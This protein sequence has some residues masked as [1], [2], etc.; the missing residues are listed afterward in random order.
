MTTSWS[1]GRPTGLQISRTK[2]QVYQHDPLH[3][4]VL[5][6]DLGHEHGNSV[7]APEAHDVTDEETQVLDRQGRAEI[8]SIVNELRQRMSKLHTSGLCQ[9]E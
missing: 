5:V 8:S 7:Q 9:V 4:D 3:V 2:L 6:K 1:R